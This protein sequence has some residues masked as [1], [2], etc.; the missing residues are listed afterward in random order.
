[1][2]YV[3]LFQSC[4]THSEITEFTFVKNKIFTFNLNLSTMDTSYVITAIAGLLSFLALIV[5]FIMAIN[6]GI[7]RKNV[8]LIQKMLNNWE[9][10]PGYA[11][12]TGS[13]STYICKNC[14][15]KYEGTLAVCPHCGNP[16]T[17]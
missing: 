16:N 13:G 7:I 12:E 6:L 1:V 8:Q 2:N 5:F 9:K 14:K 17:Y 4:V 11:K 15:K 10:E 3:K